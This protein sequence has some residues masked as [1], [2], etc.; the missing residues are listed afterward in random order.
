MI[1]SILKETQA[2]ESR[3]A[4]VPAVT[5]RL[6]RLGVRIYM[7]SGASMKAK[8]LDKDYEQVDFIQIAFAL[9]PMQTSCSRYRRPR[10]RSSM[11][12]NRARF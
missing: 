11:H 2:G 10:W 9:R 7:E 12:L 6:Q 5:S 4:L 3:V 1:V 8:F